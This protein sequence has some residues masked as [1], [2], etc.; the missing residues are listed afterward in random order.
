MIG[1][2]MIKDETDMLAE[3]LRNHTVF[4]DAIY[5]LDGTEG[6]LQAQS[7]AICRSFPQI[8]GYWCDTDTGIA[9]PL[10]DGARGVLLQHAR[11][12]QGHGHWYAVLHGDEIWSQD[13]R[14][15]VAE[16]PEGVHACSINLYH[17]F[18]HVSERKTWNYVPNVTSIEACA[19]HFM[20]PGI[21]EHRL[22]Y[23]TGAYDYDIG[24]HSRVVPMGLDVFHTDFAVKQYN[25]RTPHQAH[26]RA[27]MRRDDAWQQNHYRHLIDGTDHFFIETLANDTHKWAGLVPIGEGT[28]TNFAETPLPHLQP[29]GTVL[30]NAVQ[31]KATL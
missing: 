12:E 25:Y 8:K 11:T 9:R 20:L 13:P 18:P 27:V 2:L 14:N 28:V 22:F 23:D 5:V 19:T 30:I 21:L 16:C 10:K 31:D 6:P 7:E 26:T 4:C 24:R 17:F 29:P 3:A 1:L 15:L